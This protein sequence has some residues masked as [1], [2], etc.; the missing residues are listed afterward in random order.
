M[1]RHSF[2]PQ[3]QAI[4]LEQRIMFDGAAAVAVDQQHTA[5][6]S[7]HHA[8]AT[9]AAKAAAEH[10]ATQAS[11]PAPAPVAEPAPA[12]APPAH[13]LLVVDSRVE[14]R[15]LLTANVSAGTTVLVVNSDQDGLAAISNALRE[16]GQVDSIQILSHGAPGQFTL[17]SRTVSSDNVDQLAATLQGWREALAAGADI[18]L[19]GCD[20]GKGAT[21]QLLVTELARWTGADVA[22]SN[23]PTGNAAAGGDWLLETHVGTIDKPIALTE[24]AMQ[25][26]TALLDNAAPTVSL[27]SG[28]SDVLLG[29]TFTFTASFTNPSDQVGYAPYIDVFIPTTGKDGA[30]SA[31]DDGVSF[32][33][34]TFQG[35]AIQSF[36]VIFDA[37]G[38]ATHPLAKG[39]DGQPLVIHAADFGLRAGDTMWVLQLPNASITKGQPPIDILVTLQLSN[40][41]DTN[42]TDGAPDLT[43]KARGGFQFGNTSADDPSADPTL[44]E[45]GTHDFIV[46]PTMVELTMTTDVPDGQTVTGPNYSR[47]ITVTASTA[48]DQTL[49]NV[50]V[51][52]D[53]PN[54]IMVTSI[55]PGAGGTVSSI[56][57]QDGT[58]ITDGDA[59]ATTLAAGAYLSHYE[60]TYATLSGSVDTTVNFYVPEVDSNGAPVLDPTTGAPRSI[61]IAGPEATAQW[62]PL[63]TRDVPLNPDAV[64]SGSGD[65]ATFQVLS[66]VVYKTP[67]VSTDTGTVGASPG[68]TLT[69]SLEVDI[70]DYFAFGRNVLNQGNLVITDV[71]TD[72]QTLVSGSG[73]MVVTID[74]VT[75]TWDVVSTVSVDPVTG[76]TTLTLDLAQTLRTNGQALAALVGDLAFDDVRTAG[77]KAIISYQTT[78]DQFYGP[79][80]AQSAVNE[81]DT[82]GNNATIS[83]TVLV[84]RTT[85]GGV[86]SDTDSSTV[87]I[88]TSQVDIEVLTVD[89]VDVST[90]PAVTLSPGDVVTFQVSYDLVSGDYQDFSLRVYL[91]LPLFDV[92]GI[93]WAEGEG[94]NQWYL[95]PDHTL[96][97]TVQSV[98]GVVDGNYIVFDFGDHSSLLN[99]G[100]RVE[101]RFTMTVSDTPFGD[102]RKVT[103]IAQSDQ[104]TTPGD[105]HIVS[106]DA[107]VID[108]VAEPVLTISHGVVSSSNGTV[109]GAGDNGWTNPDDT[110][111]PA[112]TAPVTEITDV[113]GDVSG[114]DGGDTL[115]MATAIENS[116]GGDAF[117]VST[118]IDL[119]PG[120]SFVGTG[121]ADTLRVYRGD[122]TL[123]VAGTDYE[124]VGNVVTFLDPVEAH[125]SLLAGRP[126]SAADNS[127]A[128]VIVMVYDVHVSD[129]IAASSTL[130]TTATLTNYASVNEGTDFTP[131]DLFEVAG[132]QVA[133]PSITKVYAGGTLDDGDSSAAN[134]TGS[135]LVVGETM[136]YDIV[137]TL[138]EGTTTNLRIDDL[139]P[140]GLALDMSFGGGKG[141]E[142]ILVAGT[143]DGQSGALTA[144][145][146]GTITGE[147]ASGDGVGTD[148]ADAR[149][150]FTASVANADNDVGNN[151]FVIRVRLVA[152]DTIG[153]QAGVALDNSARLAYQDPDGDTAGGTAIDR[154]V[155][156]SGGTPTV[157]VVEPTLTVTQTADGLPPLGVDEGDTVNYT[158]TIG[159]ASGTDA[160][161]LSF[162]ETF[163]TA[164]NVP[165]ALLSGMTL[166][167]VIYTDPQGGTTDI[168]ADFQLVN[169][170]LTIRDGVNIDL[171]NGAKIVIQVSGVVTA[172]ADNS[173]TIDSTANVR[174]TSID[175]D[176]T[177]TSAGGERTGADGLLGSGVVND[178]QVQAVTRVPVIS[179]VQLSRIGGLPDT[180]PP[181]GG[182]AGPNEQVAVGEI[183]RYRVVSAIGEGTTNDYQIQIVLDAGLT[184]VEDG[185]IKIA[186]VSNGGVTSTLVLS[187][188]GT[189]L[190]VPGDRSS[191]IA[192][193]I[194]DGL[195]G[196]APTASI[197]LDPSIV[198]VTT[199]AQ[200]RTVITFH[201]GN[202]TNA[203]T[204]DNL[205]GVVIEFNAH[206]ANIDTNSAGTALAATASFIREG[207]VVGATATVTDTVVEPAFSGMVKQVDNFTPNASADTSTA[208]VSVRFTQSGNAPAYDVHLDDSFAGVSDYTLNSVTITDADGTVRTVLPADFAAEGITDTSD[209][210][211]I[212]LSVDRIEAGATVVVNYTVEVAVATA[213]A[214]TDAV[215]TWSSLPDAPD[216]VFQEWGGT[217]V[218]TDG[219]AD[220]ERDGSGVGPNTY[221]LREGAGLG[222]ITGTLWDDSRT[223]DGS[224]SAGETLLAGQTVTLIWGGADGVIGTGGDDQTFTTV[225][226]SNGF[227]HFSGLAAGNYQVVAPTP[228]V[229]GAPNPDLGNVRV[230][231]DTDAGVLGQVNAAVGEGGS[232]DADFG[233]VQINDAPVNAVPDAQDV[234][235][236]QSLAFNTGNGNAISVGD[237]DLDNGPNPG[238]L[239]VTLTVLHGTLDIAGLPPGLL[240]GG[241]LGSA[242]FTLTG[243]AQQI[244]DALQGL[245]YQGVANYNGS[246][247]L[248]ITT[249]DHGSFGDN[250]VGG[251]GIP[252]EAADALTDV[253]TV[254]INVIPVND[255]PQGVNDTSI[256]VEAGGTDNLTPGRDPTGNLL[257]NDIDVDK[258]DQPVPDVLHLTSV[259]NEDGTVSVT[260]PAGDDSSTEYAIKGLYG[261]L[262]VRANG[263]ARYEVDN[264]N[265]DVQSLLS[266]A[267]TWQETFTYTLADSANAAAP[268][269]AT[270][271]VTIQGANDAPVGNDDT[272]SATEGVNG[273]PGT[274]AT[275]NVIEGDDHGGVADTDVDS[276]DFGETQRVSGIR[277]VDKNAAGDLSPVVA[278]TDTTITG[279]YG[280]LTI[281]STG[282]YTY[283][284][285]EAA[286]N[287]LPAGVTVQDVFSYQVSD[288]GNLSALANLTITVVGAND[289]P[290]AADD[291][292]TAVE[293]GGLNN[294]TGGSN[295]E[296]SVLGNDTDPDTNPDTGVTDTLTV[297]GIRTGEETGS[298]IDGDVGTRLQGQY[299]WLT[300]RSDGTYTYEVDNDNPAVQALRTA[301]N[302][303]QDFFTYTVS[304]RAA[305]TPGSQSD[306][307]QI[308]ITIDGA[309]DNPV[310]TDDTGSA[311][312]GVNGAP[313]T[314]ATGNV[315][316]GDDHGGH[317]DT[318]VDSAA[319]GETQRVSGV[320]AGDKSGTGDFTTD[321]TGGDLVVPGT[322]G[323]LTIS[324]NGAYTYVVNEAAVNSLPAGAIVQDFFSYQLSDTGNLTAVANLTITVTGVNDAPVAADDGGTA[325]EAGGLNNDTGGSNAEGSVLDNDTDPD[326]GEG[327][328]L[329]ITG[330]RTGE[331]TGSGIDGDVG[332]RLQG[333]YGWLTIRA[334]GTY[335]Y[336]VDNDNPA[337]QALRT[338][339]NHLQD[340]FTYTV[341]DRAAGMPG[342]QSDTAQITITIEG[343]NDNPV[344]NDDTGTAV[345]AGVTAGAPATGNVILG[346]DHGGVADT[347][348][349]SVANGETEHVSGIRV[350]DK[351]G[352][353]DFTTDPSGAD[354]VILGTYGTLTISANGTYTYVVNE[355]AADSLPAGGSA[356][357]LFSYELSDAGGLKAVANLTITITGTNDAPVAVDDTASAEEKGGTF[358]DTGGRDPE[359]NVLTNDTDVDTGDTAQLTVEGI[360]AGSRTDG[361]TMTLVVGEATIPGQY[362]TLTI[363]T[364]GSYT[365]VVNNTL[366]AVQ[367]LR[368]GDSIL[369]TFTYHVR[370]PA[371]G[372]ALG[373]LVVTIDG[374]W[375]APV[376]VDDRN[377]AVPSELGNPGRDATGNVING[378]LLGVGADT[379]VDVPDLSTVAGIRSG[380]EGAPD[381]F[382]DVDDGSTSAN[383]LTIP[384]QYGTLTIGADGSYIYVVDPTNPAVLALIPGQSL[385]EVF[386]Y[387]SVD[388]GGL[389]DTAELVITVFGRNNPPDPHPDSGNAVEAGGLHN[390]RPGVDPGGNVLDND[391]D[392]DPNDVGN[393]S[394][395]AVR[396]GGLI[397]GGQDGVV[398]EP[399]QGTYGTLLVH[400]DGTW[401]YTV[402]NSLPAVEALRG[403]GDQLEEYFTYTATDPQG[404]SRQATLHIVISG[405]NDTPIAQDDGGEALEAGGVANGT[406]G[407]DA[408]G[409]VLD[410]D[411]DVD[412][413]GE[414]KAVQSYD[415][416]T[417]AHGEVGS[418]VAGLYGS[419][420]INADGSYRYV[421]DNANPTVQALRTSGE[422]L[423]ESFNYVM[424]DADGATSQARLVIVV[425]GAN[426]NPV[427]RDDSNVATDQVVA[428]QANGNVLPNDSDVD[429]G[430]SLHVGAIRTGTE[431][432]S[433]TAGSLG[434]PLV[435][436][437]GTLVINADG[438]YT[439]TIDM[440]NPEVLA[441]AGA[442]RVLNDYFTYTLVDA[443]GATDLAQLTITLD[444]AAPYVPPGP[445]YL[446]S[447][448]R[449]FPE[450][451]TLGFEPGLFV[452]PVVRRDAL[453]NELSRT[454]TDGSDAPMLFDFG[455]VSESLGDGL[456]LVGD[457]FVHREVAGSQLEAQL[458]LAQ[459]MARQGRVSLSADGLLSDPSPFAL[460][461]VLTVGE[462]Q[463]PVPP[464][465]AGQGAREGGDGRSG[466]RSGN[467][468]ERAAPTTARAAQT[469]HAEVPA[470]TA[471]AFTQQLKVASTRLS[472]FWTP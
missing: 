404:A 275:G 26:F 67:T 135:N 296:G 323:T 456:G 146:L 216:A 199:D 388:R 360:R 147:T 176:A 343:A 110:T 203:E 317:A 132:E 260:I 257:D 44:I 254:L 469:A 348:V 307:A 202:I 178:Y 289:A 267:N 2:R 387:Q 187:A 470:Q 263:V 114:I 141:Y 284:V 386:T 269:P 93:S 273:T 36:E 345:E 118:R 194:T 363:H 19:Y 104:V 56:T 214:S 53:L 455:I 79:P 362:G 234:N 286:V 442:G 244:N 157:T 57:L 99:E 434:Q 90:D 351:S 70:S 458:A 335:T 384:G 332:T 41:A 219:A 324:A 396:T 162:Q 279:L 303:L 58:V 288:S 328:A 1:D 291:G 145:F 281:S 308:T 428:P 38:N 213:Y 165:T 352:T 156:L 95:G 394:V 414:T 379:D 417:G 466:E 161:D 88:K 337:V 297:T 427:A 184:F 330:I 55:V 153:N 77:T 460:G 440:N 461:G 215:L 242:T 305:G 120:L 380:D 413:F 265:P 49:S 371:F 266:S 268:A 240:T 401:T 429:G 259:T 294:D 151:S 462:S 48:S 370:D 247:T 89:N 381:P 16:M 8:N 245:V 239:D 353:D 154:T 250:P 295:A 436:R 34:A 376:A 312:E 109:T 10:P 389:N 448:V 97:D 241:E 346:D 138:P 419:L 61:T 172:D 107:A 15:D 416:A 4:A 301:D 399:L 116:G 174:W 407:R 112:F 115:R 126:N 217:P 406:P 459:F 60:V 409:N 391:S 321:A 80:N 248:T 355:G 168:T 274:P 293:A 334:D 225:T 372:S 183:V 54:D 221:V 471:S 87:T 432:G 277:N 196:Q 422:T 35:V 443:A 319:N 9:D 252:G 375:D 227:F 342:S 125:G 91:P 283:V 468:G 75:Y 191:D 318:D 369:D 377:F 167:S 188:D 415:S 175:G 198:M 208:D 193:P 171:A 354:L 52:H 410:N 258:G 111:N 22:A 290:V 238:V 185:T 255:I 45:S 402:N 190:M 313:G 431:A 421:V 333:Q 264:N 446:G 309:N 72:G 457:Q 17:G 62:T 149:L 251:N 106:Q 25:D 430:D 350:G 39:S 136:D 103:V 218:G 340:F 128:N 224:V 329:T 7:A 150:S 42:L 3:R 435:G 232:N 211:G 298:G 336:E 464:E 447:G 64:L 472:P 393:L 299:G 20:V 278:G 83:G 27:S 29:D 256:A 86:A 383:G 433:G 152:S 166:G 243:T 302:Q 285:N 134:T 37:N 164:G 13:T 465:G 123:L 81:G 347:D 236:D 82:V 397:G 233:Y 169:G 438:S 368:A 235:E 100:S 28:G 426:D 92:N 395:S 189:A 102:N 378:G 74:G 326:T 454:R 155:A 287:S 226:D 210:S 452:Q 322:Y 78:I 361:G 170:V 182:T 231:F 113:N 405:S 276:V 158:I 179:G 306:T 344:A 439:Y 424:R 131:V 33:S 46:H 403:A 201:L 14:Q 43:I 441:N 40:L 197:N 31:T 195:T 139:I 229:I 121:L 320:R 311:V 206:V 85:I 451:P 98:T 143:A 76:V 133:A 270:L 325:V 30:G 316:L 374:A 200:G 331:E 220:G 249:N 420:V 142:I 160:F 69:Y 412:A 365:Y 65:P 385:R 445:Q 130:Q 282:A 73:R 418:T 18:Q 373:Q 292:G 246:D 300:I 228:E 186:I 50:V 357:D 5:D 124:V 327:T 84:D 304:D 12:P 68:D 400:A 230:R 101:L 47:S 51:E 159:N 21:G 63:D 204:D 23:D 359:G 140:P 223:P 122:G 222:L 366:D 262:Y 94:N 398:G 181:D 310:A 163:P 367:R 59:I 129:T 425:H 137:V 212:H 314:P 408:T 148:G 11:T 96:A 423:T 453:A 173:Q 180:P 119:P 71:A 280:T 261:T 315:I 6:A 24:R 382:T 338:A 444:I 411:S 207:G 467:A 105:A 358:N 237:V 341:S 450:P 272:G 32:V 253:D 392:F 108:S 66:I 449:E 209:A 127:G 271:R 463:R 390:D 192:Q 205:E 437:Y 177:V 364:D 349:D 339:D 356:Q 117:D 144:N